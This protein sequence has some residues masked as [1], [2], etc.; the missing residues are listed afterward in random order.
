[1]PRNLW[2]DTHECGHAGIMSPPFLCSLM[3]Y[4]FSTNDVVYVHKVIKGLFGFVKELLEE[5]VTYPKEFS[6]RVCKILCFEG[7]SVTY[8]YSAPGGSRSRVRSP[9]GW[10]PDQGHPHPHRL[11]SPFS[12]AEEAQ[13]ECK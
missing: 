7:S 5:H 13:K 6:P 4:Y 12:S 9:R 8:I 2:K 10:L 3:H 1:M 11:I